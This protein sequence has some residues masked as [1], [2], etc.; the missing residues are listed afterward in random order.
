MFLVARHPSLIEY[1]GP[2]PE[3]FV[4][5]DLPDNIDE[6]DSQDKK[7][8]RELYRAQMLLF[9]YELHIYKTAPDLLHAFKYREY[10]FQA[11]I[12]SLIRSIFDDGEPQ[13]QK[14]LDTIARDDIWKQ[15][16]GE[17]KHGKPCIS[18]P[19]YYTGHE[20][21]R[22]REEYAKWERDIERKESILEEIGMYTGWNGAVRP[23]DY[24]DVA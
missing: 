9:Y 14:L 13:V 20:L 15:F 24:A 4:M 5:P 21:N 19:L 1:D 10:I 18:C 22:Q 16:V 17:D 7:A 12:F 3:R 6:F 2:R 11:E 23:K 8:A